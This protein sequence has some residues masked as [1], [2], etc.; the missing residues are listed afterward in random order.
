MLPS[1]PLVG[2]LALAT[3]ERSGLDHRSRDA[4]NVT[5][6]RSSLALIFMGRERSCLVVSINAVP[7]SQHAPVIVDDMGNDTIQ[8]NK[9]RQWRRGRPYALFAFYA[10][11]S[12]LI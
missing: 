6:R 5:A 10:R 7:S 12:S 3:L 11:C 2:R 1:L 9:E 8:R 4:E